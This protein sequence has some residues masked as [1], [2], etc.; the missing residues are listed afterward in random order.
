MGS[1][2]HLAGCGN[3]CGSFLDTLDVTMILGW[4]FL[5]MGAFLFLQVVESKDEGHNWWKVLVAVFYIV[6]GFYIAR[7]PH[8][9]IDA[10]KFVLTTFFLAEG[11][12]GIAGFFQGR[13]LA[14]SSWVLFDGVV[15]FVIGILIGRQWQSSSPSS[16]LHVIGMLVGI[17]MIT[18]GATRVMLSLSARHGARAPL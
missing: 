5:L 12:I 8:P 4:V 14:G 17:S 9:R 7:H 13:K 3:Y 15:A 16:S 18:T 10:L 1:S 6:F 2:A 11:V